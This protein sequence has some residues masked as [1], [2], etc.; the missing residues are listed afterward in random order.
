VEG[1]TAERVVAREVRWCTGVPR[2]TEGGPKQKVRVLL[3]CLVLL[4]AVAC[5]R[6]LTPAEKAAKNRSACQALA[7]QQSG[8]DPLTAG[9]P[10]RTI[11]S[12]SRRGGQVVGSGA[13]VEGAAKGAVA[14]VVGGAIMGNAGRGAAAGAAGGGLMGGYRRHKMKRNSKSETNAPKLSAHTGKE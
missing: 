11:S 5:E 10:P 14:G 2:E 4:G 6:K 8:F 13:V 12:T 3:G 7:T 9:E 1:V